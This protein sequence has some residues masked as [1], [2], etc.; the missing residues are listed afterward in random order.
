MRLHRF[1]VAL[2]V[3]PFLTPFVLSQS[4]RPGVDIIPIIPPGA[5][6]T[7]VSWAGK[8]AMITIHT[9][10]IDSSNVAFPP[11]ETGAKAVTLV[12]D[13]DIT[14]NGSSLLVP[15]SVFADLIDP[16]R[17]SAKFE[18]GSFVLSIGGGDGA[19]SYGVRVYFD[20]AK[21]TRR[22][23][24]STLPPETV[25]EDTRYFLSVLKDEP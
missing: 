4:A 20:T 18:K 14:I 11:S 3:L 1:V 25:A 7:S 19:E 6:S 15:R 2:C 21:V 24:S 16:R 5:T 22:V 9:I 17:M 12:K 10:R 13:L 23:L 8:K